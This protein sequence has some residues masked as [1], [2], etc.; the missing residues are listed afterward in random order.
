MHNVSKLAVQADG[1]CSL[2]D[3]LIVSDVIVYNSLLDQREVE[4]ILLIPTSEEACEIMSD[5][6]RVPRNC[7]MAL[8]KKADQFYPVPNYRMYAGYGNTRAKYLQV[9]MRDAIRYL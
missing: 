4:R 9:S 8:N 2:L 1:Y 3:S 7:I 5:A 6:R